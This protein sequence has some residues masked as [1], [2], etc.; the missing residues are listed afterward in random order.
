MHR[1]E[2]FYYLVWTMIIVGQ[3]FRDAFAVLGTEHPHV[4]PQLE[5]CRFCIAIVKILHSLLCSLDILG[6]DSA[7]YFDVFYHSFSVFRYRS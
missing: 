4:I 7:S 3:L 2:K 5:L 6:G 1:R